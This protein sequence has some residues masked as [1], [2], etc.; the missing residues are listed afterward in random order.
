MEE[1]QDG[2]GEEDSVAFEEEVYD[3][4]EYGP[5]IG[6]DMGKYEPEV[7]DD[8]E[9]YKNFYDVDDSTWPVRPIGFTT[10]AH[11]KKPELTQSFRPQHHTICS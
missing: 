10:R 7:G 5:E 6:D 1:E 8:M 3:V 9:E 2:G 11:G 4:E